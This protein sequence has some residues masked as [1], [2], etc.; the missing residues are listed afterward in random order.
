M[1]WLIGS[2]AHWNMHWFIVSVFHWTIDPWGHWFNRCFFVDSSLMVSAS[3]NKNVPIGHGMVFPWPR[4]IY[5]TSARAVAGH[6]L[7][8]FL[9]D[10]TIRTKYWTWNAN[11]AMLNY[12]SSCR[13]QHTIIYRKSKHSAKVFIRIK[14]NHLRAGNVLA[15]AVGVVSVRYSYLGGSLVIECRWHMCVLSSDL[16]A[17]KIYE[18]CGL[19]VQV[20]EVGPP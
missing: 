3:Q 18:W 17:L 20:E 10:R 16:I 11:E 4:P 8:V 5:E 9:L 13:N 7:V 6:C 1:R 19:W 15:D 14:C 12:M 2:A